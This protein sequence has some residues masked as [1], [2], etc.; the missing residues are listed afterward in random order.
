[1]KESLFFIQHDTASRPSAALLFQPD[2]ILGVTS[3]TGE[4]TYE[5]DRDYIYDKATQSLTLPEG[6]PI[7]FKTQEQL[8]PLM[9]S[10]LPKIR[11]TARR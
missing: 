1:M 8:Y 3:A 7:P 5:A 10:D 2:A 9:T 4:T 11:Q 6:S